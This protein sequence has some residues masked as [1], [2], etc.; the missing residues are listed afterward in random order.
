MLI[1]LRIKKVSYNNVFYEKGKPIESINDLLRMVEKDYAD[2]VAVKY[3]STNGIVCKCY[4][5]FVSDVRKIVSYLKEKSICGHKIAL[6]GKTSYEYLVSYLAIVCSGNVVIPIDRELQ[7]SDYAP[8]FT[9]IGVTYVFCDY[10]YKSSVQKYQKFIKAFFILDLLGVESG[11]EY[12][13][14]GVPDI[15]LNYKKYSELTICSADKTAVIIYTSGTTGKS[16][17][18]MLTQ[19]NIASD[20]A[21]AKRILGLSQEDESLSILPMFHMYEMTCDVL[22]MFYFGGTVALNDS[23][24]N[25]K[26]NIKIFRPTILYCVP[27]I[28]QSLQKMIQRAPADT[29]ILDEL[30]GRLKRIVC[31]GAFLAPSLI[32]F[33]DQ[34]GIVVVQG[35]GITECSP[36]VAANPDRYRK[37]GS[38]GKVI[39]CCEV[40]IAYDD[41]YDELNK[42]KTGEILVKG[43]NVMSGYYMNEM[44][45]QE[46][47]VD[48]WF[49]TGD[50]GYL[51]EDDYLYIT[52]RIKNLI[53][54]SNGK[55]VS[56]ELLEEKIA[57]FDIVEEVV[58]KQREGGDVEKICAEIYPNQE[59]IKEHQITNIKEVLEKKVSELNM[60]L[61][62][63]MQIGEIQIREY[64]FEKTAT[65]KIRRG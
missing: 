23:M 1:H 22:L 54:L 59:Y 58:V 7:D 43:T 6:V 57:I 39:S 5:E 64:N 9:S 63:Y 40:K 55:N 17:G 31:G 32:D 24:K 4:Q 50:V 51:D 20:V 16:K 56:A 27:I 34:Y 53:I 61:P 33:F 28:L 35:Y 38:I 8:M 37:K 13:I 44:A 60:V 62:M 10:I 12:Q 15:L 25:M 45:T 14:I 42:H 48:G 36:L 21:S 65:N 3:L 52:G 46:A 41:K 18:V 47:F 11:V 49:R 2:L 29:N 19:R 26:K 30:G